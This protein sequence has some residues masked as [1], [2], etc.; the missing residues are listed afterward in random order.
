[1]YNKFPAVDAD[2]NF[3][4]EVRRQLVDSPE[5]VGKFLT[6]EAAD[7]KFPSSEYLAEELSKYALKSNLVIV[8]T[9]TPYSARPQP[10]WSA[11]AGGSS[12]SAIQKAIDTAEENVLS[13]VGP[14]TVYFPEGLYTLSTTTK[15]VDVSRI[16]GSGGEFF[17]MRS[18]ACLLLPRGVSLVGAG[19]GKT[20]L[21]RWTNGPSAIIETLNY[22][23]G[24][25]TNM[26]LVGGGV[27]TNTHGIFMSCTTSAPHTNKNIWFK[28]LE[29]GHMGLYGIGHQYGS[30][31]NLHYQDLWLHDI[32]DDGI[33]H[34]VR[35][36]TIDMNNNGARGAFFKNIVVER[37]G[38]NFDEAS[39]LDIR[40][41]FQ[42]SNINVVD[43][44]RVGYRT[45]GITLSAGI[46]NG[47]DWRA[48]SARGILTNFYLE[49]RPDTG[50]VGLHHNSSGPTLIG[51]GYI[52]GATNIGL[53][54]RQSLG[55]G[56]AAWRN[57]SQVSN[58]TV[59]GSREGIPYRVD[60]ERSSLNHISTIAD[61]ETFD[62]T[63]SNLVTN[64]TV[65]QTRS[66][67]STVAGS[68][69]VIKNDIPLAVDVGYTRTG[70]STI[71][72]SSPVTS[73]DVIEV[74]NKN[75][76]G[77][78]ITKT[79]VTLI[80]ESH[81]PWSSPVVVGPTA[82]ARLTEAGNQITKQALTY[83]RTGETQANSQLRLALKNLGLVN[84]NTVA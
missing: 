27:T 63:R 39:G 48:A 71:T 2:Y 7:N 60:M 66:P 50:S 18:T 53:W 45:H 13:G 12:T 46:A 73:T 5:A 80:G 38:E 6:P 68:L 11:A 14:T 58:I 76:V 82:R 16:G 32:G 81:D 34:K 47:N 25:I 40:G 65:F 28:D 78:T 21:K 84:D 77:V 20:I 69:V 44:G 83:S 79:D 74:I 17:T 61:I 54:L 49:A 1:M 67:M 59:E 52:R 35:Q 37:H 51:D 70:P 56:I 8:V 15:N 36:G 43:Y 31:Y 64:Q 62:A 3:P 9:D 33:D 19:V 23:D 42:A 55:G 57:G 29:I 24:K 4:P 22:S 26:S 75:T 41:R 10:F 30:P 72:L